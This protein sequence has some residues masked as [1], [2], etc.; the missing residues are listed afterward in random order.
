MASGGEI[1]EST[2]RLA[3]QAGRHEGLL[4]RRFYPGGA[5]GPIA[6]G[7]RVR[8]TG[9][10]GMPE[11]N[12]QGVSRVR[13]TG[14]KGRPELNDQHGLLEEMCLGRPGAERWSVRMD[15]TGKVVKVRP[16]NLRIAITVL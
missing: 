1:T 3:A 2:A 5:A 8:I 11:P 13:I 4:R 14:L 12:D 7:A 16:Q 15:G 9:L 10:N 6:P